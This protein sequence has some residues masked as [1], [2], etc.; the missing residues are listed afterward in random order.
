MPTAD[1]ISQHRDLLAHAADALG[2]DTE[3]SNDEPYDGQSSGRE[4]P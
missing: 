2:M 1:L 3:Y 4:H